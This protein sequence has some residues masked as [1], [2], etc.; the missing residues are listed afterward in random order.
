VATEL[1]DWKDITPEELYPAIEPNRLFER[2]Y[3]DPKKRRKV[4]ITISKVRN[5]M[6]KKGLLG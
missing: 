1:P 2:A 4:E 5:Q 3:K 6:R